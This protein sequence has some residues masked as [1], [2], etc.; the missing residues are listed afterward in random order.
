MATSQANSL[1][2]E[3]DRK[4][5]QLEFDELAIELP[6][7]LKSTHTAVVMTTSR[8]VSA[9]AV[10]PGNLNAQATRWL[11]G[12]PPGPT[13]PQIQSAAARAFLLQ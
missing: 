8:L 11:Q 12:V 3:L 2:I 4:S 6:T 9:L 1:T 13:S 10:L 7:Q 5:L